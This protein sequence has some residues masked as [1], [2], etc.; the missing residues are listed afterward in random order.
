MHDVLDD[1]DLVPDEAEQLLH[2]GYPVQQLLTDARAAASVAD[3][4]RLRAIARTLESVARDGDWSFDEP[5]DDATLL[6]LAAAAPRF[7]V[8]S[9]TLERR[10]R[11]AWLGRCVANTM[12]KP[13]EG[14]TRDEV[15]IY[16]SAVGQ[17]PQTGYVPLLSPLPDGVSHLH[18]S[19]SF[20]SAGLFEDVPRDDDLDWTILGLAMLEEYGEMLTTEDIAR[21][22]LDRLPFTQTFTAE[23]AAYRNLIRGC[24]ARDAATVNNPYREWIGAL[25]RADI[26]G[27]VHPGNPGA[28]AAASLVDARLSH[29]ANGVFGEL[30]AAALVSTAL[31]TDSAE[32]ALRTAL[33]VVPPRSRL[34]V[35][36]SAILDLYAAG[37]TSHAALAWVDEHLGH[38]NWV[39]TINNAALISIGLL[40]GMDFTTA[41][42]LT[43]SGGRDTDSSAATVGSVYGAIHGVDSIPAELVGTT[44]VRVRSAV[45]DFDRVEI[46]ELA[47]RTVAVAKELS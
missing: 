27:Y 43:I 10:I 16:L 4:E 26:F 35:A 25:I 6:G 20:A 39:H 37:A 5:D 13:V 14:L 45:K 1:R 44:H 7:P 24:A 21:T 17:W 41:V 42:A 46:A 32:T 40:W 38:Y 19:S 18:E 23:R 15:R 28:A 34:A 33:A 31:A 9:A 22:W 8:D 3:Y 2:S 30:W 47:R 29:V 12:G 11:G 36:L